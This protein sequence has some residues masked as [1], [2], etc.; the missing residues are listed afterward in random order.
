LLLFAILLLNHSRR[1]TARLC[2]L[3]VVVV[4]MNS[5]QLIQI[6]LVLVVENLG[7]SDLIQEILWGLVIAG[8]LLVDVKI[9]HLRL[10]F[11]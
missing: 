10:S 1:G 6:F 7:V 5:A 3:G 4:V 8:L 9:L 11:C 2:E